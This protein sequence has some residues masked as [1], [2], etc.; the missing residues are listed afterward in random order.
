MLHADRR[1]LLTLGAL[2]AL[3]LIAAAAS[4]AVVMMLKIRRDRL[5]AEYIFVSPCWFLLVYPTG[6]FL[7]FC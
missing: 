6:D 1:S 5:L 3:A 4:T 7:F 2:T